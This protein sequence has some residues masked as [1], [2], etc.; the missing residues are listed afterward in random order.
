MCASRAKSATN[1]SGYASGS[2]LDGQSVETTENFTAVEGPSLVDPLQRRPGTLF[3]RK[4]LR[5]PHRF[6]PRV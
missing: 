5:F 3:P 4:P 1:G 6:P 2:R